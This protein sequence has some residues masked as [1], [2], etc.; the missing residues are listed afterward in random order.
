MKGI[1][2]TTDAITSC[3]I[4]SISSTIASS[5]FSLDTGE[6]CRISRRQGG[7]MGQV[8]ESLRARRMPKA[9]NE[10]WIRWCRIEHR[11]C[12]VFGEV[13]FRLQ[14]HRVLVYRGRVTRC[15]VFLVIAW[16]AVHHRDVSTQLEIRCLSNHSNGSS[17]VKGF[18][19]K[20]DQ[21]WLNEE[22]SFSFPYKTKRDGNECSRN[23]SKPYIIVLPLFR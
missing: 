19:E 9:P 18:L 6:C 14:F 13:Y 10:M 5:T 20:M 15:R 17:R 23:C 3:K 2:S 1:C 4:Y 8:R 22:Q 7:Y 16:H 11:G 12:Q 21:R